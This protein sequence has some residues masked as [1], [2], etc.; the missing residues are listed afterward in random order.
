MK[1]DTTRMHTNATKPPR[2][3]LL[4]NFFHFPSAHPGIPWAPLAA[5]AARAAAHL[6]AT[7]VCSL[8]TARRLRAR[9]RA[10]AAG[11]RC[12]RE[13]SGQREPGLRE[14]RC[15][16]RPPCPAEQRGAEL[17]KV[18]T[19]PGPARPLPLEAHA[20]RCS[21]G[22]GNHLASSGA[23]TSGVLLSHFWQESLGF[24]FC[25]V[26]FFLLDFIYICV[27]VRVLVF[28]AALRFGKL[29]PA[30]GLPCPEPP[31]GSFSSHPLCLSPFSHLLLDVITVS[32]LL[33]LF[34]GLL[35]LRF[36]LSCYSSCGLFPR[37]C[38]FG[39]EV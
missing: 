34:P 20:A 32:F 14:P 37:C 35:L 28:M 21:A 31:G 39:R 6:A 29:C 11:T 18:L 8:H 13:R 26:F 15:G 22:F 10:A 24:L 7:R 30:Q 19:R 16:M 38:W 1:T 9:L 5:G 17:A 4:S 12:R 36:S 2:S 33:A 23:P 3:V 25:W 27:C